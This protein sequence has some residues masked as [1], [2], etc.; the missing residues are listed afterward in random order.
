LGRGETAYLGLGSNVGDR[1]CNIAEAVRRI[2]VI[3][4]TSVLSV[5]PLYETSPVGMPG[6]LFLNAVVAIVTNRGPHF[7]MND[8]QSIE[9]GMGRVRSSK[10]P[11]P[12]NIDI[13]L[14]LYGERVI[15]EKGLSLP[16]PR[17]LGRRFVVEPLA[18]LAPDL[19]VPGAGGTVS[20]LASLLRYRFP[21]Q[22]VARVGRLE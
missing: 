6:D 15:E 10:G 5:S 1:T 12:R 11:G 8:L 3:P 4:G 18:D 22:V 13:D 21:E 19:Q 20:Q 7:L 14:L 2:G 9:S 16:H 17:M